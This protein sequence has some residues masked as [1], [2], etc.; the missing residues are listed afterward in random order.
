MG[1][2]NFNLNLNLRQRQSGMEVMGRAGIKVT[3]SY[4]AWNPRIVLYESRKQFP[5]HSL[6]SI[7]HSF[8]KT[9][10]RKF[11]RKRY[12]TDLRTCSG[13][14]S[15]SGNQLDT[16]FWK[17]R[18]VSRHEN[19]L[20]SISAHIGETVP[21]SFWGSIRGKFWKTNVAQIII[22]RSQIVLSMF[23]RNDS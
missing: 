19:D 2:L 10:V 22:V 6:D 4:W 5:V 9:E 17:L 7:R 1:L 12:Q 11:S 16:V 14:S 3:N 13:N 20:R 21:S 8:V 15:Q 23:R 18:C